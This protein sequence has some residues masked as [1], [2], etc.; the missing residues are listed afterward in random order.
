MSWKEVLG[1]ESKRGGKTS[2]YAFFWGAI[3]GFYQT[4]KY[5][6]K[7]EWHSSLQHTKSI[8]IEG[9]GQGQVPGEQI[10]KVCRWE[11][12]KEALLKLK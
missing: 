3:H 1:S 11:G 2:C 6:T 8:H 12:E 10:F 4:L 9:E 7:G 5:V